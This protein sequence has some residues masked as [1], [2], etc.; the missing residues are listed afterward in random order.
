MTETP[1]TDDERREMR[2]SIRRVWFGLSVGVFGLSALFLALSFVAP[3][4]NAS[5]ARWLALSAGIAGAW[6]L[7]VA[8]CPSRRLLLVTGTL[9]IVLPLGILAGFVAVAIAAGSGWKLFLIIVLKVLLT[10]MP[11]MAYGLTSVLTA[12]KLGDQA[13]E[14]ED[15]NPYAM[16]G[17]HPDDAEAE[18][19]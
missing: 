2:E 9:L 19:D 15:S 8:R 6:A 18:L 5:L 1:T 3:T 17:S 7:V 13:D 4:G 16:M 12:R 14:A 10:M 11:I